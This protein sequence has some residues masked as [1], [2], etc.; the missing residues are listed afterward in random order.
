MG[1]MHFENLVKINRNKVVREMPGISKPTNTMCKH[2]QHGKQT[3]VEFRTK[4]CSTTKPL[5]IVYTDLCRLMRTKGMNVEKYF[6]FL[7]DDYKRMVRVCFL[8]K[9]SEAFGCF[10][11]LKEMVENETDLKIKCLISYNGGELTSK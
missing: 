2:Y 6:M 11:I 4:E 7:I 1:H 9:N 3:R 10:R 8:K 5:E